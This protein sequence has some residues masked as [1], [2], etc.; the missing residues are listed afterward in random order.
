MHIFPGNTRENEKNEKF[1]AGK[2]WAAPLLL[3]RNG[4]KTARER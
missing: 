3:R 4:K 1:S 2:I